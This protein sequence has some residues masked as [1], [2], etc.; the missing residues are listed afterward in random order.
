MYELIKPKESRS[1]KS[2]KSRIKPAAVSGRNTICLSSKPPIQRYHDISYRDEELEKIK[3]VTQTAKD[4]S[5]L[6]DR[7]HQN[8]YLGERHF[9]IQDVDNDTSKL[10]LISQKTNQITRQ[11]LYDL[12]L[13]QMKKEVPNPQIVN[14]TELEKINSSVKIGTEFT[15]QNT[16]HEFKFGKQE[17]ES[18]TPNQEVKDAGQDIASW[19]TKISQLRTG[20]Q[21][22]MEIQVNKITISDGT[23]K[24]IDSTNYTAKKIKFEFYCGPALG[25]INWELNID[26]DP[27]CI[28]TQTTPITPA[29]FMALQKYL[30]Y[31]VFDT[32][33]NLN[34]KPDPNPDTG[35]GGHISIDTSTAFQENPVYFRNFLVLY[36]NMAKEQTEDWIVKCQDKDNAPFLSDLGEEV[37]QSFQKVIDEFDSKTAPTIEWL[38]NEI[39]E[40]VYDKNLTETLVT[41]GVPPA[42]ALHY[43]AVNLENLLLGGGQ[44]RI[45]MRRFDAQTS[46]KILMEDIS[47]LMNLLQKSWQ[48]RK[49]PIK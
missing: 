10:L 33:K 6:L 45:E 44:G 4:I 47:N 38:A 48:T 27:N 28:E 17:L 13:N 1:V 20:S 14:K 22:E 25:T 5:D 34:L 3:D 9:Q 46:I 16:A 40:K 36:A 23:K 30:Q 32:A 41:M 35:G 21:M 11:R 39:Q 18:K 29:A 31:A 2:E 26:L 19:A 8:G 43:Q 37:E 7:L 12:V 24:W 42:D 15:F 49:I